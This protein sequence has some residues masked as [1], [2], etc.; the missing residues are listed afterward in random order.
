MRSGQES[1]SR[2]FVLFSYFALPRT[3][4]RQLR[5]AQV[6]VGVQIFLPTRMSP[7]WLPGLGNIGRTGVATREPKLHR[8]SSPSRSGALKPLAIDWPSRDPPGI[9]MRCEALRV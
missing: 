7:R 8:A 4:V 2:L 1:P 6:V 5:F 3:V 9:T